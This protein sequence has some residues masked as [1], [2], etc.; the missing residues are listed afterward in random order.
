DMQKVPGVEAVHDLHVWSVS[1]GISALSC[2]VLIDNL[3]PSES[4]H[5]LHLINDL[6]RRRY[7]IDHATIQ[8][9]CGQKQ[10]ACCNSGECSCCF[11]ISIT[12]QGD[13]DHSEMK[14]TAPPS[15]EQ[16]PIEESQPWVRTSRVRLVPLDNGISQLA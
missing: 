13:H 1:S 3:P 5:I 12:H 9:E 15:G 2:H 11:E 14:Y 6:L 8:F 4:A 7:R 16:S 10:T